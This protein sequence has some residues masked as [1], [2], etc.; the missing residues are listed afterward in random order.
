MQMYKMLED[1]KLETRAKKGVTIYQFA[2]YDYGLAADDTR[3]FGEPHVSVTLNQDGSIPSFTVPEKDIKAV[4]NDPPMKAD[5]HKCGA[6]L[7]RKV[8]ET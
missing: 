4:E 5:F 8:T 2:G 1:S 7:G 6:G 3:A